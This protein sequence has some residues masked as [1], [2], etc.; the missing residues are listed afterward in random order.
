MS[1]SH[2]RRIVLGI[3]ENWKT[4]LTLTASP[5]YQNIPKLSTPP[6]VLQLLH[7]FSSCPATLP[8]HSLAYTKYNTK[9]DPAMAGISPDRSAVIR[10]LMVSP[11]Q[12]P[13]KHQEEEK[14]LTINHS[15]RKSL[16]LLFSIM[17]VIE[18][19]TLDRL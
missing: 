6:P 9:A 10:T 14:G 7:S 12:N 19:Q 15:Q 3:E 18:D 17:A 1:C 13:M 5:V 11:S 16:Q 4:V 2:E 8:L